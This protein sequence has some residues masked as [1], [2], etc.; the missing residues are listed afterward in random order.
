MANYVGTH[1]YKTYVIG[2]LPKVEA[3]QF[4]KQLQQGNWE[5]LASV[6]NCS[7][8][9]PEF[10]EIYVVCGGN[11]FLMKEALAFWFTQHGVENAVHW[12]RFP[13]VVQEKAKLMKEYYLS[14]HIL[15]HEK[16]KPRWNKHNMVHIMKSLVESQS[17]FALH[18]K[19]CN[20]LSS[21]VDSFIEH[22]IVHLRPVGIRM[23]L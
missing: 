20:S 23:F 8:P 13:Y 19:L 12:H 22:N 17:G 10:E 6:Y 3:N 14:D 21:V 7:P 18:S 9:I 1:R 16:S 4:W 15:F 5:K 2:D 11:I